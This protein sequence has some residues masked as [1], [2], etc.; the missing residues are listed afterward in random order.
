MSKKFIIFI[1]IIISL[2][3][4]G[5]ISIQAYWIGNAIKVKE[6]NFDTSVNEALSQVVDNIERIEIVNQIRQKRN[7]YNRGSS[8]IISIDSLNYLYYKELEAIN[9]PPF[10][11][12]AE[13]THEIITI[14]IEQKPDSIIDSDHVSK[15]RLNELLK[16]KSLLISDV[17]EDMFTFSHFQDIENRIDTCILDSLITLELLKKGIDTDYEYGIFSS[18]RNRM[19][20]E[21]TGNYSK[22]LLENNLSFILFPSDVFS[23][24]D[25][26]MIY[27]PH[28]RKFLS[29]QLSGILTISVFLILIIIISFLFTINF[30][31]KE[32][33]F[34]EMKTDFI[35]NMTHEFKTPIS[36]IALACEALKDKDLKMMKDVS[37]S[38]I[39]IVNEENKRLGAMAE[40]I[41]QTAVL[42]KGKLKLNKEEINI[43]HIILDVIKNIGIQVEINDGRIVK[44]F[45]ASNPVIEADKVHLTNV[46]FNLLENAN[47]YSPTKPLITIR[48]KNIPGGIEVSVKDNGVG[49]SKSDQKKIFDKLYRVPTGDIHNFKGF[50]LGLSYV[51]A[52]VAKHG[53]TVTLESE[54]NVG[55]TFRVFIPEK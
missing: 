50:G 34:A 13:E 26:L 5:F 19:V 24:P 22:M 6:I 45:R 51:K 28:E 32:K 38:Y 54:I 8:L 4:I 20:I 35:N 25:Y 52:I 37:D 23:D 55:S 16:R 11:K 3:L 18:S 49:I 36:T 46:I 47:K 44:D 39:S 43:H 41:L 27:F 10:D 40:K 53:G 14:Q 1:T 21:K 7:F 33:K 17:F 9:R 12:P 15:Q 48:T 42:E 29:K 31:F 30:I 2:A